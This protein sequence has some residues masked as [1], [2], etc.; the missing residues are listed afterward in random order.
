LKVEVEVE[1]AVTVL[2]IEPAGTEP[3]SVHANVSESASPS[4]APAAKA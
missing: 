2:R 1:P 3:L 4:V